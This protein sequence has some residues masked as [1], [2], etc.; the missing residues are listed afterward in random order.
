MK[1]YTE[2]FLRDGILEIQEQPFE[3]LLVEKNKWYKCFEDRKS[4]V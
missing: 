1:I 2:E 4:V 3:K